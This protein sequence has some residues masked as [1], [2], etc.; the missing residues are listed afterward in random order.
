MVD[1]HQGAPLRTRGSRGAKNRAIGPSR[2]G[3]TTEVH[4]L[5]DTLGRPA[6]VHL[7][8][9]DSSDVRTAPDVSAAAPGRVRRLLADKG[10][11]ANWLRTDLRKAGIV[12]FIPGTRSPRH[13]IRYDKRRHED[14]WRAEAVFC[15]LKDFRR[16]ATRYDKLARNSAS[17]VA[18]AAVVAFR[19][20]AQRLRRAARGRLGGKRTRTL[21]STPCR[22]CRWRSA[23]SASRRR[24]TSSTGLICRA[25]GSEADAGARRGMPTSMASAGSLLNAKRR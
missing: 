8:P 15:R 11:D 10:Y 13:P 9:G 22:S 23:T 17:A 25:P 5:S 12:P 14:R 19:C 7:T 24:S 21:R 4:V 1:L 20:C 6:V 3:P 18:L 16:V 2:G